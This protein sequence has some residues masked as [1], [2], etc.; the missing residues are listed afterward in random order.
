MAAMLGG[1]EWD[2]PDED[3]FV[4]QV[5]TDL[6]DHVVAH[7]RER[8]ERSLKEVLHGRTD[9]YRR[10]RIMV[11]IEACGLRTMPGTVFPDFPRRFLDRDVGSWFNPN[12]GGGR[13]DR[14]GGGGGSA[15]AGSGAGAGAGAGSGGGATGQVYLAERGLS[16]IRRA[17]ESAGPG[18]FLFHGSS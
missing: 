17:L 13:R 15:G 7:E 10:A 8:V 16:A 9:L 5:L 3:E 1:V 12:E 11:W 18:P 14:K 4:S 2:G 6:A